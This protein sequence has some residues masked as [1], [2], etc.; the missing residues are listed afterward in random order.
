MSKVCRP[1]EVRDVLREYRRHVDPFNIATS[2]REY[3]K[4]VHSE[5][6]FF[7][8]KRFIEENKHLTY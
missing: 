6:H 3:F 4:R 8:A 2:K 5:L 7:F 1:F